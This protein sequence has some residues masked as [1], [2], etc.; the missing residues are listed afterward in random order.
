[1]V[2][3]FENERLGVA[4]TCKYY[5]SCD[6]AH[7]MKDAN[8]DYRSA[9]RNEEDEQQVIREIRNCKKFYKILA[10]NLSLLEINR[11]LQYCSIIL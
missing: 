11:P 7:N 6:D 5:C 3:E 9:K 4:D 10:Y 2:C 1:M 8:S